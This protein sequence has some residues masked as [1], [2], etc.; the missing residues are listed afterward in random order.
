MKVQVVGTQVE[1]NIMK[2]NL[3]GI[4][5]DNNQGAKDAFGRILDQNKFRKAITKSREIYGKLE[6]AYIAEDD[7]W[8]FLTWGVE[9]NRHK[10]VLDK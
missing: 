9:R 1:A 10:G 3:A 5:S 8:K 2:K 7:F 4:I 6:D